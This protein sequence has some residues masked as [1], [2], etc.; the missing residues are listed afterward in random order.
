M[1]IG[2]GITYPTIQELARRWIPQDR[3]STA[4]TRIYSGAGLGTTTSLLIAPL[5]IQNYGWDAVFYLFGSLGFF[6]A[7]AWLPKAKDAPQDVLVSR[8]VFFCSSAWI[9]FYLHSRPRD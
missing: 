4:I 5:V 2:E 7:M 3:R 6:W 8:A 1:G 9:I